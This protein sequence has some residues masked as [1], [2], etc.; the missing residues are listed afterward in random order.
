MKHRLLKLKL[1]FAGFKRLWTITGIERR[2]SLYEV[3]I[4]EL[5][6]K[7]EKDYNRHI[8]DY[9]ELNQLK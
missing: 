1:W 5:E 2:F 3:R 9:L 6:E 8:D 7:V 4:S